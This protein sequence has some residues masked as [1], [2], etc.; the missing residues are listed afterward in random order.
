MFNNQARQLGAMYFLWKQALRLIITGFLVVLCV[1]MLG[2]IIALIMPISNIEIRTYSVMQHVS[3]ILM[4]V[5]MEK[6]AEKYTQ[7]LVTRATPRKTVF[8]SIVCT[9]LCATLLCAFLNEALT[10]LDASIAEMVRK[11]DPS[12]ANINIIVG[13]NAMCLTSASEIALYAPKHLFNQ[14]L[15]LSQWACIFYFYM[16]LLRRWR[17]VTLIISIGLPVLYF[18]LMLIPL[19][20]GWYDQLLNMGESALKIMPFT[21]NVLQ[22]LKQF[23]VFLIEQ[24]PWVRMGMAVVCLALSYPVMAYTPQPK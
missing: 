22:G 23:A 14:F 4:I 17:K 2:N 1:T 20:T 11:V 12:K 3:V 15:S 21:T 18:M 7:F 24:W 6:M 16:T 8:V 9:L 13:M 10:L 19:L 5:L